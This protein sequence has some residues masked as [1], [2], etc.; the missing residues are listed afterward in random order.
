[1]M[2]GRRGGGMCICLAAPTTTTTTCHSRG[3][4]GS[5]SSSTAT[6]IS[7]IGLVLDD[8]G[9]ND[10]DGPGIDVTDSVRSHGPAGSGEERTFDNVMG[11]V[12]AEVGGDDVVG[13]RE[14]GRG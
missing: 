12:A 7:A 11:E 8:H 6:T 3:S 10:D 2:I 5:T 4:S 1:M 14:G 13:C 9:P